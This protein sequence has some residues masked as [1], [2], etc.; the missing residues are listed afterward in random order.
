M[1]IYID[2]EET[3]YIISNFGR[4]INSETGN[5]LT[6]VLLKHLG[7]YRYA[8][9]HNGESYIKNVAR[10]IAIAF[11]PL[12]NG[13]TDYSKYDADHIDG[14]KT[15][16]HLHNIQ[17]LTK[18]E[19][20]IK[21]VEFEDK[22]RKGELNGQAKLTEDEVHYILK[23][24]VNGRT[25][26]EIAD[27]L[28][29]PVNTVMSVRTGD[30]W[31]HIHKLY[32]VS[33]YVK[34]RGSYD[35]YSSELKDE[36]KKVFLENPNCKYKDVCNIVNMEYSDK[37]VNMIKLVK[38]SAWEELGLDIKNK[39]NGTN[40]SNSTLTDDK[41]RGILDDTIKGLS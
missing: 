10:W 1:P 31:A 36:I 27:E 33:K 29:I 14:D 24:T 39:K 6:P 13:D 38:N 15:H 4:M 8:V 23:C 9:K 41:V 11:L 34:K 28:D 18:E 30:T 32:D 3:N 5:E 22:S 19:N 7:R 25:T 35:T 40:N 26:K 2:G 16:D 17:W 12:P 20:K 21:M 37:L